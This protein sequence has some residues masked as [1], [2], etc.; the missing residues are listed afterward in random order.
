[1]PSA[2]PLTPD[3]NLRASGLDSCNTLGLLCRIED[4]YEL[5]FPVDLLTFD[6]FETP[7]N[8]WAAIQ[9]AWPER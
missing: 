4:E 2:Q 5:K 9:K 8:L 1:M 3:L 7:A 6:T